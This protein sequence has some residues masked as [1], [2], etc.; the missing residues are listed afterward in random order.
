MADNQTNAE[1]VRQP[2]LITT[3]ADNIL[4]SLY[5]LHAC[6]IKLLSSYGDQNFY[7]RLDKKETL[8]T[9]NGD[10][11]TGDEFVLKIFNSS[12]SVKEDMLEMRVKMMVYLS[13]KGVPCSVP[14]LNNEG[15]YTR[16][17]KFHFDHGD[18]SISDS[19]TK[20][21]GYDGGTLHIRVRVCIRSLYH[22]Y[23]LQREVAD[24][25]TRGILWHVFIVIQWTVTHILVNDN[26][27]MPYPV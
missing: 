2:F 18:G 22:V 13:K 3:D 1:L 6:S 25:R 19:E 12:D 7:V 23:I 17:E 27:N 24:S 5:G 15:Q 8:K 20:E 14:I 9:N 11:I 21:N 16:L 4:K 26:A 10:T